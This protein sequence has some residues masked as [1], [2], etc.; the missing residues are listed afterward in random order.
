M[1]SNQY[2]Y[3]VVYVDFRGRISVEGE[4]TRIVRGERSTA[5]VRRFL[6]NLGREGWELVGVQTQDPAETAYMIFKKA[7]VGPVEEV[8]RDEAKQEPQAEADQ[9]DVVQPSLNA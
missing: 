9:P 7:G 5:F 2:Q 3:K 6:D 4:E 1:D 8:D